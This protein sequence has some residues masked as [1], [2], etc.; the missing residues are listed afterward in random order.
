MYQ[1]SLPP[2]TQL[3]PLRVCAVVVPFVVPFVAEDEIPDDEPV[4]GVADA[5]WEEDV[6]G[7]RSSTAMPPAR[8]RHEARLASPTMRRARAARGLR[9]AD[10]YLGS[11]MGL[12]PV[13]VSMTVRR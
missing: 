12:P 3:P 8:E 7:L 5:T 2:T 13:V 9:R 1:V 10:A 11:L 6:T 4:E